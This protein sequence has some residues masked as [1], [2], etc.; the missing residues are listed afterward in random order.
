MSG[1]E[2]GLFR[3][4]LL[5]SPERLGLDLRLICEK[6]H[7]WITSNPR[8]G[9]VGA[10]NKGVHHDTNRKGVQF[11]G[12]VRSAMKELRTTVICLARRSNLFVVICCVFWTKHLRDWIFWRVYGESL[13]KVCELRCSV[14][15][16]MVSIACFV[17]F[18]QKEIH[19]HARHMRCLATYLWSIHRT[20]SK[21]TTP[22]ILANKK[23]NNNQKLL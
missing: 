8:L 21:T 16:Q 11:S 20:K 22:N 7:S 2:V 1:R 23:T 4:G 17:C 13:S 15:G 9:R 3:F 10:R 6:V 5:F 12:E 19:H 18:V 14:F